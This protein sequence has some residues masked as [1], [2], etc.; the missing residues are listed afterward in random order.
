MSLQEFFQSLVS[1][2]DITHFLGS[3]ETTNDALMTWV[4][5]EDIL[6]GISD[7]EHQPRN[8]FKRFRK[9]HPR[10]KLPPMI[11]LGSAESFTRAPQPTVRTPK[12][13][14]ATREGSSKRFKSSLFNNIP[15]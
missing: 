9:Y 10:D 12:V 7:H 14:S 8:D 3:N 5:R 6:R 4:I 2:H 1:G 13:A 11:H 15:I